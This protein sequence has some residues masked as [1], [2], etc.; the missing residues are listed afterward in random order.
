VEQVHPLLRRLFAALDAHGLSWLLL[1]IP[2]SLAAPSGDVDLL[3]APEDGAALRAAAQRLGFVAL[4]GWESPPNL[5]L[6]RYD[7][8]SDCWLVLDVVTT[9]SFRSV[10]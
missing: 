5:L 2:S 3:V 10:G 6:V 1:R 9:I 8:P 4:P 7:R